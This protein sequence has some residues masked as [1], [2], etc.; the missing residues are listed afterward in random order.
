MAVLFACGVPPHAAFHS[1]CYAFASTE[2][3]ESAV[4][5]SSGQLPVLS[6]Q[7]AA[8]CTSNPNDCGGTGGC[9][10]GTAELVFASII[11]IGGMASQWT[12]PYM[13]YYGGSFQCQFKN[14]QSTGGTPPQAVVSSYVKLPHNNYTAVMNTLA[15]TGPVA[16]SVDAAAWHDYDSG[17]YTGCG[18]DTVTLDHNVQMVGYG[19]DPKTG[20]DYWLVR[21]SW[22]ASYG[23]EGFI[24]VHRFG[25]NAPCAEDTSPGDGD[26]CNNGPK[27]IKVCGSCGILYDTTYPIAHAPTSA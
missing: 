2:S 21:N 4:A 18:T 27:E 12:Y 11:S 19:T 9:G 6:P 20:L 16:I 25:M 5:I 14:S 15:R 17:V 26:G 3:V 10:G 13:S 24:R 1:S 22:G 8:F 23:E 7:Q